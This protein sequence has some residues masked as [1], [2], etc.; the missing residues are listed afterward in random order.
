MACALFLPV[1]IKTIFLAFIMLFKPIVTALVG[2][3]EISLNNLEL[4]LIV[5]SVN[6]ATWVKESNGVPGSLKAIWPSLPIPKI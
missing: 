2:T 1:A 3:S 5:C 4:S 6:S